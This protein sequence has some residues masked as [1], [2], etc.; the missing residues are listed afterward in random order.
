M[1]LIRRQ[2]A[3]I[4]ALVLYWPT[5]FILA[6]IPVPEVVRAAHMSDKSLHLLAYLMLTFLL[7]SA[8]RPVEKVRWRKAAVWWI[9]AVVLIYGVC[10]EVLQ[11]LVADRTMDP[12]DYLADVAG[13]VTALGVLAIMPFWPA[14]VLITGATIYTL[15]VITRANL[16][17]LLPVTMTLFHLSTHAV[18]TFL[19]MGC[20]RQWLDSKRNI[21]LWLAA[22]ISLPLLLVLVTRVSAVI[23]G[24]VFEPSD[25][26]SAVAGILA[27]MLIVSAVTLL[28]RRNER[29]TELSSADA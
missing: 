25:T 1:T 3:V 2:K 4:A 28:T 20:L 6:H 10:D 13:T 9:L 27:A 24:K 14:S 23:S 19:W 16:T 26:I 11:N 15:A 8:I 7:W 17:A 12:L 18:F 29:Q 22:S 21:G 5:L